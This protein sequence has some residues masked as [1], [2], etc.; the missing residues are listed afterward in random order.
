M[1]LYAY[2]EPTR[3]KAYLAEKQY[4]ETEESVSMFL[5]EVGTSG[6][7]FNKVRVG[8][9]EVPPGTCVRLH[10]CKAP[11]TSKAT[12]EPSRYSFPVCCSIQ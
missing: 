9:V 2:I 6:I 10:L 8:Y 12:P 7:T 1:K 4:V 11:T 5:H 3:F